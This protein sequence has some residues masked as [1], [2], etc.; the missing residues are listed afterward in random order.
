MRGIEGDLRRCR[1]S[2][3]DLNK[4]C[5]EH[6]RGRSFGCAKSSA[7]GRFPFPRDDKKYD[8]AANLSGFLPICAYNAAVSS[9]PRGIE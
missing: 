4:I 5:A 2:E 9:I 1:V 8:A 7:A 6:S 3:F